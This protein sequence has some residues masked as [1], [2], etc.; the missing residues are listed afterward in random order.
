MSDQKNKAIWIVYL[1]GALPFLYIGLCIGQAFVPNTSPFDLVRNILNQIQS[2]ASLQPSMAGVKA[3]AFLLVVYVFLLLM[4]TTMTPNHRKGEE[5]GSASWANPQAL[6][7]SYM[8]K[9]KKPYGNRILTNEYSLVQCKTRDH[10]QNKILSKRMRLGLNTREHGLNLNM[11]VVGGSGS[12]KT[13]YMV[14]PNLLQRNTSYIVTDPK[15]EVRNS[16]I[17]MFRNAKYD[18]KVLNLMEPRSSCHYNPFRYLE[19]D[20]D[21]LS[22][23]DNLFR[24]TNGKKDNAGGTDF[25]EKAESALLQA[26]IFFVWSFEPIDRQN[27]G[28]VVEL[29]RLASEKSSE[30]KD[31]TEL[32]D[33][34]NELRTSENTKDHICL[35]QYDIFNMSESRTRSSILISAGVRLAPFNIPEIRQLTAFD[36]IDIPSIG[37][38][39]TVCYICIPDNDKSMNFII[40]MFYTQAFTAL[41]K[42]ADNSD[43]Q[44]LKHHVHCIMDEFA[45]LCLPNDFDQLLSTMRSREISVSIIIQAFSQLKSIYKDSWE[46]IVG[47]CDALVYLGGN[48]QFTHEWLSKAIGKESI[49]ITNTS[50]TRS[51]HGSSSSN[52]QGLGRALITPDEVRRLSNKKSIIMLRGERPVQDAKFDLTK[53]RDY[54]KLVEQYRA[55]QFMRINNQDLNASTFKPKHR[56]T[57]KD[58]PPFARYQLDSSLDID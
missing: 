50:Q 31:K 49:T 55:R 21:V 44:R 12:G 4:Y 35:K 34:F 30:D 43:G 27:F 9:Q 36:D 46:K 47:N 10:R 22:M 29:L 48:E 32:D 39:K 26:L 58:G 1:L 18:V 40:S 25:W 24:N 23:I 7:K 14:K 53:H 3:A 42:S 33:M 57:K 8:T 17:D 11:L 51:Q 20:S 16:S 41:Y 52:V 28:T 54:K 19:K 45:N 15:Q 2:P 13:R 56:D 37:A 38:R 5:H 6:A